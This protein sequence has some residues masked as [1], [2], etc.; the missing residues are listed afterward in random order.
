MRMLI[1]AL[2]AV[3]VL[4]GGAAGAYFYFTQEA[5]A[6]SGADEHEQKLQE[7]KHDEGGH[8]GGS[9]EFVELGPLVLPIVDN[10]GVSQTISMVVALEVADSAAASKVEKYEPKLKD[11]FI[12]DMYGV[13]NRHAALKGG[14]IQVGEIKQRLNKISDRVM[15]DEDTVQD[16]LLQVVQ[17]R[18]I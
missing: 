8:G 3:L 7:A 12:Q 9:F 11:A 15:G 4:G 6:S 17:Q 18:P 10:N 5:E 16:V 1:I 14:V 13:L 2:V